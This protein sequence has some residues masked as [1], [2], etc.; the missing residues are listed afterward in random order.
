M[1]RRS[2]A[3]QSWRFGWAVRERNETGVRKESAIS[4]LEVGF[5]DRLP[6]SATLHASSAPCDR[7]QP[8]RF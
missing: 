7:P 3:E 8:C 6:F 2:R 1:A 5:R 4:N